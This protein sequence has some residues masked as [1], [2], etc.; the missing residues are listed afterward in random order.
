MAS[1]SS[2]TPTVKRRVI[3]SSKASK[4][5]ASRTISGR[6]R[7]WPPCSNGI[8]GGASTQGICG[9]CWSNSGGACRNP[10]RAPPSGTKPPSPG[11]NGTRGQ[12][13]AKGRNRRP[14]PRL[15]RR[16]EPERTAQSSPDLGSVGQ[17]SQQEFGFRWNH[18]RVIPE[19]TCGT[20]AFT[21]T[22]ARTRVRR[23]PISQVKS[24][25]TPE[26]NPVEYLWGHL[27]QHGL[28]NF[29]PQDLEAE[30]YSGARF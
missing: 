24:G 20:S 11:G 26:L 14:N 22:R 2:K 9:G 23:R 30:P 19:V 4:P 25:Y 13:Q 29:C 7:G 3:F 1:T 8:P 12:R 5:T 16:V 18:L 15:R 27:Q 17:M 6:C 10:N 21:S 28:A